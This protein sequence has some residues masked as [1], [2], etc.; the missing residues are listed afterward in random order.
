[1]KEC[2]KKTNNIFGIFR[3]IKLYFFNKL[4]IKNIFFSIKNAVILKY[5][6]ILPK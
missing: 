3:E 4:K 6:Q 2:I 5:K 1:M